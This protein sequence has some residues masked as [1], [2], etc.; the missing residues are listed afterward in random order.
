MSK[1]RKLIKCPSCGKHTIREW[2]SVSDRIPTEKD[3]YLT[4]TIHEEVYR[5][6]WNGENFERIE[7]IIAWM[8]M[9]EPYK[10][11]GLDD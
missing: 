5:T 2:I 7:L 1:D 6:Y 8:P 10:A 11:G 3:Y 9:P 4:T